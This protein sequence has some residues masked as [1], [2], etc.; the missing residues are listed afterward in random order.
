VIDLVFIHGAGCLPRVFD[1]QL[2]AFPHSRA[3]ALPGHGT[4]GEPSSIDAFVDALAADL[5]ATGSKR[6][7]LAGSSLGGAIA[8]T[9][10]LRR[11]PRIACVALLGSSAA[12]R[13]TP[14]IFEAID[15]DFPTAAGMLAGMF[16]HEQRPEWIEDS[17][18]M[19]LEVGQAQTRRDFE[20][21]NA[22]DIR[23]RL[24]EIDVPLLALTGEHDVM[25]PPKFALSL[26]DRVPGAQARIVGGAGH[27]LFVERPA[28]TN[29]ALR[30]FV[31]NIEA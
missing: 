29:D 13:V 26:A 28:E 19:M 7:V 8:L 4:P 23:Q 25:T 12:L 18:R 27:L 16:Y 2:A 14:S 30:A 31:T 15:A 22:Y 5:D 11:D 9:L 21:C 6:V 3:I 1:A 20:A 24:E 17:A 10:A